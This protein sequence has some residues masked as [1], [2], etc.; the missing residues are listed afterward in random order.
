[1]SVEKTGSTR[2]A[3]GEPLLE[4]DDVSKTFALGKRE[5]VHAVRRVSLKLWPGESL[6]IVGESGCGKTTLTRLI[7]RLDEPTSGTIRILGKEVTRARERELR[8]LRRHVQVVFQD[9]F[10]SLNP[11]LRV[12]AIVSEPLEAFGVP[13]EERRRRVSELLDVVG[14]PP[15]AGRRFPHAFSGGQR[16]RIG[17]ARALAL[18]P[19]VL[20]CD[21]AV[22]ALDV[23]IQAQILNLLEDVR[24]RYGLS[25]LFISHNLAVIR[26]LCQRVAVMHR[27]EIVELASDDALFE[28]PLHPYTQ[29]LLSAVLEPVYPP[30]GLARAVLPAVP[31]MP[32]TTSERGCGYLSRCALAEPR[33]TVSPELLEWRPGRFARCHLAERTFARIPP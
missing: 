23:S 14:L 3:S 26:Y 13:S 10:A 31:P 2:D 17:I 25:L 8:P 5:S 32:E 30:R 6:G 4:L 29:G 24:E 18:R 33:C 1:M 15:D 27:G 21:E 20:V 9:P 7:L 16:Q 19:K 22:S 12:E 11:R 28:E